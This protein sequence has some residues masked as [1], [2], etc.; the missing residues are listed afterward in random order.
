MSHSP[1]LVDG[2]RPVLPP[3][4]VVTLLLLVACLW[5]QASAKAQE[6]AGSLVRGQVQLANGNAAPPT[7]ISLLDTQE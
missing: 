6:A 2:R 3:R 7:T 4:V 5:P 1:S